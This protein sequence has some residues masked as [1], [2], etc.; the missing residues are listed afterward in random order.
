MIFFI[1]RYDMGGGNIQCPVFPE[2]SDPLY[3]EEMSSHRIHGHRIGSHDQPPIRPNVSGVEKIGPPSV[4]LRR[5]GAEDIQAGLP[6]H[7]GVGPD[8][9]QG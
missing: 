8:F 3:L 1:G 7:D 9:A 4:E 6:L 2:K 5:E